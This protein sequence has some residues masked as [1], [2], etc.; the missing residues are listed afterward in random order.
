MVSNVLSQMC[1]YLVE[2]P[3]IQERLAREL[4]AEFPDGEL[5]YDKL[6]Q[7][8]Y[9]DAF[10]SENFRLGTAVYSV[11]KRAAQDTMLGEYKLKKGTE[12]NLLIYIVHTSPEHYP[13]PLKFDPERFM[14]KSSN[15][16]NR[17]EAG[18]YL[19]FSQGRRACIGKLLGPL[20]L[21]Y[22]ITSILLKYR[23]KKPDDFK[24]VTES[25]RGGVRFTKMPIIFEKREQF[26]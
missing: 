23:L 22:L 6:T 14:D 17:I 5:T 9:L 21:K 16:P 18:T 11:P 15:N 20:K 19:P 25:L 26:E 2:Y 8:A 12:I 1:Q 13:D 7:H 3:E 24:I 4:K 10:L